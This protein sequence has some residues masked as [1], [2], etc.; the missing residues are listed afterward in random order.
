MG[1]D[2]SVR[3]TA[4][5]ILAETGVRG[6]LVVHLGCGEGKLTVALHMNDS[7]LVHGLDD[8]EKNV[9][10]ARAYITQKNI[11]GN[12]TVEQW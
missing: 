12:V 7:Y 4:G 10:I 9:A 3:K 6:G 2:R 1:T 11:Y 5:E 8:D